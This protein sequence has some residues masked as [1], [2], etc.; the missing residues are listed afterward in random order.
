MFQKNRESVLSSMYILNV[1]EKKYYRV[2]WNQNT[3]CNKIDKTNLIRI[4]IKNGETWRHFHGRSIQEDDAFKKIDQCYICFKGS[5][6]WSSSGLLS[7]YR[8]ISRSST[9][10]MLP[11]F[12]TKGLNPSFVFQNIAFDYASH[13]KHGEQTNKTQPLNHG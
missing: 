10:W 5:R 13:W 8:K 6:N 7:C 1:L 11:K 3:Q 2:N 4:C 12:E 9:Q